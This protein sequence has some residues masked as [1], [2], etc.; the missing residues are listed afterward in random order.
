MEPAASLSAI[1]TPVLI[2]L[3]AL[4][5]VEIG[6]DVVALVDLYRRP[7][8]QV[9]IGNKWIWVVIILLVNLLGPI[10]YLAIG[11]KPAPGTA[12]FDSPGRSRK[13]VDSVVDSL[14]GTGEP[15]DRS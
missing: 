7:T 11:R 10:L 15:I 4:A 3:A 1:S 13:Q 12:S 9:A 14:Y 8:S 2:L 6:L 5:L